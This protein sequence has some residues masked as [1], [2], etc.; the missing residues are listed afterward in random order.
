MRCLHCDQELPESFFKKWERR[1]GKPSDRFG[2]P[3]C[4]ADHVCREIGRT[5]S[6]KPQ[7]SVRLWGH[8]KAIRKKK[9]RDKMGP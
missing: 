8:L 1:S 7:Y 2:C 9:E 3:H 5:P 4:G 6:G